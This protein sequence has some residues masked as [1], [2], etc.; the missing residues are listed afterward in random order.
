MIYVLPVN[1]FA[2]SIILSIVI[3]KEFQTKSICTR[4]MTFCF[5]PALYRHGS[6]SAQSKT[7]LHAMSISNDSDIFKN[8]LSTADVAECRIRRDDGYERFWL[9]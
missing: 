3:H 1:M 9:I 2:K 7:I 4:F 6:Q 8:A 5:V